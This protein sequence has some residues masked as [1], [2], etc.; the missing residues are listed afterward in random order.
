MQK[1]VFLRLAAGTFLLATAFSQET[2]DTTIRIS[3]NLVQVDAVV[4][5][6]KGKH[7][8]D[9]QASDFQILQDGKPQKITHFS[10]I[11]T[12]APKPATPPGAT[13]VADKKTP[14]PP[15]TPGTRLKVNQVR[16]TIALV[17]DDL[18]LS[19][20]SMAQVRSSLKKFVD[21]QME[22]GDLVAIMRTGA[23]MGALQS[24]T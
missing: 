13:Q 7:V 6:S 11:A 17:V 22:P 8:S 10:Y 4:T 14:P 19:F 2:A 15:S 9:L 23:G 5:D 24:F 21:T 18:G 1:R 20:E 12:A 16:R 3:V